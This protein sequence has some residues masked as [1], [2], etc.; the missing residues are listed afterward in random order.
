MSLRQACENTSRCSTGYALMSNWNSA[1][2]SKQFHRMKKWRRDRVR[3]REERESGPGYITKN[4]CLKSYTT[5]TIKKCLCIEAGEDSKECKSGQYQHHNKWLFITLFQF[6]QGDRSGSG[7][8]NGLRL[9]IFSIVMGSDS[10]APCLL[11]LSNHL[12]SWHFNELRSD[13]TP[14]YSLMSRPHSKRWVI[15]LK[16]T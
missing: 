3:K 11:S 12:L 1:S 5:G 4:S 15:Q 16:R 6:I 14:Q 9:D 7:G 10:L 13:A 8:R 2:I